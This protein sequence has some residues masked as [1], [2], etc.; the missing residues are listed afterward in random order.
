MEDPAEA[1]EDLRDKND[2]EMLLANERF[3]AEASGSTPIALVTKGAKDDKTHHGEGRAAKR[4]KVVAKPGRGGLGPPADKRWVEQWRVDL[5]MAGVSAHTPSRAGTD[6]PSRQR[7]FQ[8]L[9]EMLALRSFNSGNEKAARAYRLQVKERIFRFNFVRPLPLLCIARSSDLASGN[10]GSAGKGGE[11]GEAGGDLPSRA[12]GLPAYPGP[13]EVDAAR[14]QRHNRPRDEPGR[15]QTF[16]LYLSRLHCH[17]V[18]GLDRQPP[19]SLLC[20]TTHHG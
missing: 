14:V 6:S 10:F 4:R 19:G 16:P 8:R 11:A 13:S 17:A 3:M 2:L 7:Q 5:K 1:F 20:T 15:P 18:A 9:M 12:R